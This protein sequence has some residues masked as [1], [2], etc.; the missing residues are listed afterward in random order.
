[1]DIA[2]ATEFV[3]EL[4]ESVPTV[5]YTIVTDAVIAARVADAAGRAPVSD[6]YVDTV[7]EWFAAANVADYLDALD[8][9]SGQGAAPLTE[10]DSEG[11]RF[12]FG[13]SKSWGDIANT[14]RARSRRWTPQGIGV[15]E[16]ESGALP[17]HPRSSERWS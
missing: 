6:E 10:V 1:M 15:L 12:K 17:F 9:I 2:Q 7:D 14:L 13:D 8:L 11:A 5:T 3:T 4:F 16:V